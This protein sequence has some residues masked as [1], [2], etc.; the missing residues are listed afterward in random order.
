MYKGELIQIRCKLEQDQLTFR[1]LGKKRDKLYSNLYIQRYSLVY[2]YNSNIQRT[3]SLNAIELKL[4]KDL[5]LI[6]HNS[7]KFRNQI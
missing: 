2:V 3:K 1:F 6:N 7:V 4:D 5:T